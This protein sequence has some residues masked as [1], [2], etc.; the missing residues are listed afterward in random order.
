MVPSQTSLMSTA[1]IYPTASACQG[2][3]GFLF[4]AALGLLGCLETRFR[5][6]LLKTDPQ[7]SRRSCNWRCRWNKIFWAAWTSK[8][9]FGPPRHQKKNS[10]LQSPAKGIKNKTPRYN[11]SCRTHCVGAFNMTSGTIGTSPK[12]LSRHHLSHGPKNPAGYFPLNPGCL[13]TGSGI[14]ISWFMT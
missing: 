14:L 12:K 2:V 10:H 3:A 11:R 13:M 4:G 6:W 5:V 9:Q 1:S 8:N 7:W